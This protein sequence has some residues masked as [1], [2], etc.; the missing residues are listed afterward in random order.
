MPIPRNLWTVEI[1]ECTLKWLQWR[2]MEHDWWWCFFER[3]IIHI[4][5]CLKKKTVTLKHS[6]YICICTRA[7]R[8]SLYVS[9]VYMRA[10]RWEPVAQE[11]RINKSG[12]RRIANVSKRD[13]ILFRRWQGARHNARLFRKSLE[14]GWWGTEKERKDDGRIAT[15]GRRWRWWIVGWPTSRVFS[16]RGLAWIH[17]YK[18]AQA[19]SHRHT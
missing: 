2:H 10:N 12:D 13:I 1:N 14:T 18:S 16:L 9:C 19:N 15:M 11:R 6:V 17:V 5:A 8:V 3:K 7:R 4:R